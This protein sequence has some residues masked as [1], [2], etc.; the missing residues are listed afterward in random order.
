MKPLSHQLKSVTRFFS[1]A[2]ALHSIP[3]FSSTT[4]QIQLDPGRTREI[5]LGRAPRSLLVSDPNVL[6]VERVGLTNQ[7]RLIP[8]GKGI[9]TLT[10]DFPSGKQSHYTI[11]VGS[12]YAGA[13]AGGTK[14]LSLSQSAGIRI[15]RDIAR[16]PGLESFVEEGKIVVTG[17]ISSI[18]SF[19]SLS[20]MVQSRSG[21]VIPSFTIS[22]DI[23]ARVADAVT[24]D[25]AL[26]GEQ[27]LRI[28]SRNGVVV[29]HG[30]PTS[31][32][33]RTRA[34]G[35][36]KNVFPT[37]IDATSQDAGE[38]AMLQINVRFIEVGR[39]GRSKFGI[40]L[41]GSNAAIGASITFPAL[42][43]AQLQIAPLAAFFS[44]VKEN[45]NARE[46]ATPVLLT[47]NGEKASFLAGGEVPIVIENSGTSGAPQVQF[48]PY[49]IIF[50]ATPRTQ[51]DGTI[52]MSIDAEFSSIDE[53]ISY[54]GVPGFLSRKVNTQVALVSGNAAILT[55]LVTSRDAKQVEKFPILGSIPILGEL[56]KSRSFKD[57]ASELWI[58]IWTTQSPLTQL[59]EET[60][61]PYQKAAPDVRGSI[62]D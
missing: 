39:S 22:Q 29:L 35:L 13:D 55:G 12:G 37:L 62:L 42:D 54:K 27:H 47:R 52:W 18:E 24:K 14:N 49:G 15:G 31:E 4:G 44:A 33:G 60:L 40:S 56:F 38:G 53:S 21:M 20:R 7:V 43:T 32:E 17:Q 16:I 28:V 26:L 34:I 19:H 36:A 23:E 30:T 2:L 3:A 61:A 58:A 10:V 41:P 1:F 59:P 57:E 50:S 11:Q 48:K 5:S 8:R 51:T 25:L 9:S 46:I 45:S 6:D